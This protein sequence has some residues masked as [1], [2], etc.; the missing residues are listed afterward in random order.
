[1]G[2]CCWTQRAL[3]G[4]GQLL[5]CEA[6]RAS[7]RGRGGRRTLQALKHSSR[8]SIPRPAPLGPAPRRIPASEG[9]GRRTSAPAQVAGRQ[10]RQAS[11]PDRES[12]LPRGIAPLPP[13]PRCTGKR[14][15]RTSHNSPADKAATPPEGEQTVQV[16]ALRACEVAGAARTKAQRRRNNGRENMSGGHG[17][18]GRKHGLGG[19]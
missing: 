6:G 3:A 8:R 7:G 14:G 9:A 19:A 16:R 1:M 10:A 17:V 2:R 5:G 15:E 13:H 12:I 4:A 11:L 18:G